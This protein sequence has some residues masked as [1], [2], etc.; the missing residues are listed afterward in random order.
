MKEC[1]QCHEV[2]NDDVKFCELHGVE[3]IGDDLSDLQTALV[4]STARRKTDISGVLATAFIGVLIGVCLCLAV[5][6]FVVLPGAGRTE[7]NGQE[8]PRALAAGKSNQTIT[9]LPA[10]RPTLSPTPAEFESQ[11][12]SPSS[13]PK[14]TGSTERSASARA[15]L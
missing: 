14:E 12:A 7:G 4:Q 5:Y 6:A 3:L 2:F 10:A 8:A 13:A 11:E 15:R 1:P 9:Q